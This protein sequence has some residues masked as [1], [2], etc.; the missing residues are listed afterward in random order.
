MKRFFCQSVYIDDT[1][2]GRAHGGHP[3]NT[4]N[5]EH[6]AKVS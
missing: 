4:K 2:D 3:K 1:D 6:M 5:L